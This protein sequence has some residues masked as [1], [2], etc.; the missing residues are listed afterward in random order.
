MQKIN[1]AVQDQVSSHKDAGQPHDSSRKDAVKPHDIFDSVAGT[2]TG[3]L[4]AIMLGKLGMDIQDCIDEY[5]QMS[6][7]TFGTSHLIGKLTAGIVH[8]RYSGRN[9][10]TPIKKMITKKT[11]NLAR[12][13]KILDNQ[14]DKINW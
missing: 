4:A 7:K 14:R 9:L 5:R 2:S 12:P 1:V 3:G 13:L 8:G 11:G 6:K 10:E